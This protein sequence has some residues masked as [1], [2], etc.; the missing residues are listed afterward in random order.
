M[1]QYNQSPRS[2]KIAFISVSETLLNDLIIVAS[3]LVMFFVGASLFNMNVIQGVQG[4]IVAG[5]PTTPV[6]SRTPVVQPVDVSQTTGA[7]SFHVANA[8]YTWKLPLQTDV[9][10]YLVSSVNPQEQF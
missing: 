4:D 2:F 6:V 8:P 7:V 3:F 1:Y 9:D 10:Y 5:R